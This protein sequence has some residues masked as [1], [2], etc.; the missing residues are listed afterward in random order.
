VKFEHRYQTLRR[1]P[2]AGR[3]TRYTIGS[4]IAAAVSEITFAALFASGVGTTAC[5]IVAFVAGAVPN[6]ILNRR[7]AWK[8][9]GRPLFWR[10]IVG[11]L[12]TSIVTL[13]IAAQ[14][15]AWTHDQV[16]DWN[17]PHWLRVLAVTASYLVTYAV[18]FA[19]KF[20]IYEWWVF[21]ERR[22]SRDVPPSR[23]D[24]HEEVV[25]SHHEE[26]VP[27]RHEEAPHSRHHVPTITR[28]NR[29]P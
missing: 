25:P 1:S 29:A 20:V 28:A 15:T 11:Y 18:L 4:L 10:E 21:S 7:W 2:L 26:M 14:A 27:S 22:R 19:V 5:T 3:V 16:V 13:F 23:P 17:A 8:I 9:R 6:W 24:H 12:A